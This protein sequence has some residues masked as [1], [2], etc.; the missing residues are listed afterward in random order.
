VV[1]KPT[2]KVVI[3]HHRHFDFAFSDGT[4]VEATTS[5]RMGYPTVLE[6]PI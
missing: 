2:S 1:Q 4:L 3:H 6:L 5:F